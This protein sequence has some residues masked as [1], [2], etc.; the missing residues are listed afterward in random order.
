METKRL[1]WNL[2]Q[3]G[4]ASHVNPITHCDLWSDQTHTGSDW[5][6]GF[7]AGISAML[8]ILN[9]MAITA[10]QYMWGKKRHT[11]EREKERTHSNETMLIILNFG[12]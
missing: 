6:S 9:C 11:N 10:F 7:K 3:S 12:D 1:I 5:F 8:R 2:N 4:D